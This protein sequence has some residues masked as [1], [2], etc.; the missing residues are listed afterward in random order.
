MTNMNGGSALSAA[1]NGFNILERCKYL[2]R[3]KS[4]P[5]ILNIVTLKHPCVR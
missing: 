5:I 3:G 4:N 2:T 1:S